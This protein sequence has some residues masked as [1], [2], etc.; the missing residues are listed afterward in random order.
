MKLLFFIPSLYNSGGME[1]ISTDLVNLLARR[2]HACGFVLLK[3]DTTSFFPVDPS[4]S[5]HSL[6]ADGGV[7]QNRWSVARRLREYLRRERPDVLINVDV[8][9]VQIAA[10]AFP[11]TLGVKMLGWDQFSMANE[12]KLLQRFKRYFTACVCRRLIVLTEADRGCYRFFRHKVV[13]IGNFTTINPS[14]Q[15]VDGASHQVLS[16]GRLCDVKG[17][18]LLLNAWQKVESEVSDW[19]LK[20]VGGGGYSTLFRGAVTAA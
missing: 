18:D 5:I 6:G 9:M 7:R 10:L 14:G 16:V 20:I 11:A 15:V 13:T 17:F 19:T 3:S 12:S 2:G 4:V 8:S 1:R